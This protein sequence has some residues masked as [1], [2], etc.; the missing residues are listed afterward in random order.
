MES[1]VQLLASGIA[2]GVFEALEAWWAWH[3]KLIE[4][5]SSL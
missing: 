5:M 1:L 4:I 2:N 3:I